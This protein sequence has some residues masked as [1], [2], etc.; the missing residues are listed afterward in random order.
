[1]FQYQLLVLVLVLVEKILAQ[2]QWSNIPV[3]YMLVVLEYLLV[4]ALVLE[5][6]LVL[7]QVVPSSTV[8]FCL[9]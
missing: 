4:L 9:D 5:Q 2:E 1:L 8:R 6:V 3:P 7:V